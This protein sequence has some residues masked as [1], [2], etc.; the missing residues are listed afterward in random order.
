MT[1]KARGARIDLPSSWSYTDHHELK[2]AY[3]ILTTLVNLFFTAYHGCDFS[4]H[5]AISPLLIIKIH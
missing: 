4:L 3:Y 5:A 1:R 2:E